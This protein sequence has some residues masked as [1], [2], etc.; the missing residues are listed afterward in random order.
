MPTLFQPIIDVGNS[1]VAG[2]KLKKGNKSIIA[3]MAD[4]T[5]FF[6]L[7]LIHKLNIIIIQ[8]IV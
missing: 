7:V 2:T 3:K 4:R 8:R 5:K 6:S 1:A